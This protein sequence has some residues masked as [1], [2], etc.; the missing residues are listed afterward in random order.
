[1]VIH[2]IVTFV[3]SLVLGPAAAA[4][5]VHPPA[6]APN[7]PA[8]TTSLSGEA[9][10]QLLDG[11][12]MGLAK[13]A[14]LNTYPGPKHVLALKEP[15]ALT[16]EQERQVEAIRQQMLT[17][18]RALGQEIVAAERA[19][20]AAFKS[21]TITETQLTDRVATIARLNG[22]LRAAHLRAHL[23]TK[24]LLSADQVRKYYEHR[25]AKH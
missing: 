11:D 7:L 3:I 2:T 10:Q 23:A 14:E 8:A 15:L 13:P 20:D 22:E 6:S 18:A 9:V 12:G 19:L 4:Q 16:P 1:M 17:R 5:H 21:G 24:P 25:H